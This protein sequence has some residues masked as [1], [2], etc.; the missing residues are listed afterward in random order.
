MQFF[1]VLVKIYLQ[2]ELPQPKPILLAKQ[3]IFLPHA[4]DQT[5]LLLLLLFF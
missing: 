3:Q 2:N 5:G 1:L 4:V